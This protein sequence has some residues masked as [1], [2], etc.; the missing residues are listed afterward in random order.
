MDRRE[1]EKFFTSQDRW[2]LEPFRMR[3]RQLKELAFAEARIEEDVK[4]INEEKAKYKDRQSK[5]FQDF[6]SN[7]E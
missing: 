3:F 2:G 1:F 7:S 4:R 5:T 6:K